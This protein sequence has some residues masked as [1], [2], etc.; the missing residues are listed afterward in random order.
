M[1]LNK[2]HRDFTHRAL[3][4]GSTF[5]VPARPCGQVCWNRGLG[6]NI[7][8]ITEGVDVIRSVGKIGCLVF[9]K[10]RCQDKLSRLRTR[11]CTGGKWILVASQ[12]VYPLS[13]PFSR[14]GVFLIRSSGL[15]KSCPC[16]RSATR[17]PIEM[18][19]GQSTIGIGKLEKVT[20]QCILY[21]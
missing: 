9:T 3:C 6:V 19:R 1:Y 17:R 20:R 7:G 15:T 4:F 2:D 18:E 21:Q 5:D 11:N 8:F 10:R 16:A 14:L 13:G 12:L